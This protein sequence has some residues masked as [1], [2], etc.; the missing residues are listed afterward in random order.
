MGVI[1]FTKY[2]F[3]MLRIVLRTFQKNP[4][5][6]LG[7]KMLEDQ[8]IG[9]Q[10]VYDSTLF[11]SKSLTDNMWGPGHHLLNAATPN[12]VRFVGGLSD[13]FSD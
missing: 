13:M 7:M 5:R 1:M 6:V 12:T 8:L 11:L 2:M 10:D 4:G 9:G 3:R